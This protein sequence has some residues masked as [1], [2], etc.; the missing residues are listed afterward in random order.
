ME[1]SPNCTVEGGI[2][3]ADIWRGLLS[4]HFFLSSSYYREGRCY[5]VLSRVAGEGRRPSA[6]VV[7]VLERVLAGESQKLLACE[8]G[9]T[10]STIATYCSATLRGVAHERLSSRAPIVV[11][12]AALAAR[13]VPLPGARLEQTLEDGSWVLSVATPGAGY[14][15]LLSPGEWEVAR[16][17]IEGKTHAEIARARGTSRRTIANQLAAVFYKVHASGRAELRAKAVVDCAL[18]VAK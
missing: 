12:M 6:K 7:D 13:G 10:S 1:P 18:A 17:T 4:G 14:V 8:L 2:D 16:A 11:V 5:T 3:L 15:E 9:L